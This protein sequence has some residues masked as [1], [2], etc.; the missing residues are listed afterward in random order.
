MLQKGNQ[1]LVRELLV[2]IPGNVAADQFRSA[3]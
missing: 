1:L 2:L 3:F